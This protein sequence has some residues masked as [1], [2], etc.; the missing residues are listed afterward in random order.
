MSRILVLNPP[1]LGL[2]TIVN[3]LD[4]VGPKQTN[5]AAD[6]RVVQNLLRMISFTQGSTIGLPQ[7]T[8]HFDAATGFWIYD[9]Q[10]HIKRTG[11]PNTIVDGI[12]SPAHGSFY[13][14]G[15]AWTIAVFNHFA[16]RSRPTEYAAFVSRVSSGIL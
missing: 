11:H 2:S 6:V 9:T 7:V 4:K 12:V 10:D 1:F 16:Q 15:A 3:V 5:E 14:A 8:G 13:T